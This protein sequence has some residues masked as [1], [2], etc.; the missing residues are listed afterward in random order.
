MARR[1]D[2]RPVRVDVASSPSAG[3]AEAGGGLR[4]VHDPD[5][6][7]ACLH[8]VTA[9]HDLTAGRLV[10]HPT[11]GATWPVVVRDLFEALGK[12]RDALQR[13][14]RDDAAALLRVWLRA[15]QVEHLVVLRAHR[16]HP[17]L[18]A[19]LAELATATGTTLWPVWHDTDP[20]ASGW[21]G[22]LWSWQCAVTALRGS[23][24]P[25]RL[26]SVDAI[27]RDA[28]AEARREARLLRVGQPRQRRFT[29]PGCAL[30]ALLQRLTIDAVTGAELELLLDAARAG[31]ATEGLT[32][33]LPADA[34]AL[35]ALGPRIDAHVVTRLRRLACPTSA[36]AL[37]LALATDSRAG[38]LTLTAPRRISPDLGQVGMLT[39][40]Y[41]IPGVAAPLLHAALLDHQARGLPD[42][43]L[44]VHPAGGVLLTQRMANLIARAAALAGVHRPL[45]ATRAGRSDSGP[46]EPFAATL[47]KSGAV[48]IDG[49]GPFPR[50][51]PHLL[52]RTLPYHARR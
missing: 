34:A 18:L 21:A 41:R 43:A 1:R 37:L 27:H 48:R 7:L 52:R 3:G 42:Y 14:R 9:L 44:F 47:V 30:G 51:R 31:F 4:W 45:A 6:D 46:E 12:R 32:L 2:R 33:V 29:Q 8:Q 25:D 15:E 49:A 19:M 13:A 28:V 24:S 23:P 10:C 50:L 40:I 39:G 17:K 38:R 26:R 22:E 16:L 36:A 11:P 20:P 35:S 5:D